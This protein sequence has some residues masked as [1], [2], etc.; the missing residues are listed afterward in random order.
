MIDKLMKKQGYDKVRENEHGAYYQKQEAQGYI[1]VVCVCRKA[2]GKHLLQSYDQEV[3]KV[4]G[5]YYNACAGVEIPVLLLMWV[6][7]KYL[8]MRHRWRNRND[9]RQ[10]KAD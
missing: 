4:N 10:R 2:S 1:H 8:S 9:K 7:A 5:D 6:K 3:F